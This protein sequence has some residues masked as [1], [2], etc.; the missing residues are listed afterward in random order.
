MTTTTTHGEPVDRPGGGVLRRALR[1]IPRRTPRV[2]GGAWHVH[3][4]VGLLR[5]NLCRID[6]R[7]ASGTDEDRR[8][9]IDWL[10]ERNEEARRVGDL[11]DARA[12]ERELAD[13]P[14]VVLGPGGDFTREVRA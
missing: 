7:A 14:A 3:E 10:L 12:A 2:R 8:L 1:A 5:I 4:L 13:T 6:A 9:L 11:L